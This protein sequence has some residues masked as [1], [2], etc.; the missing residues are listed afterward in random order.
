MRFQCALGSCVQTWLLGRGLPRTKAAFTASVSMS[1]CLVPFPALTSHGKSS[2]CGATHMN[3]PPA[4]H[5][6]S[7][8]HGSAR[9]ADDFSP[10]G[11]SPRVSGGAREIG[12]GSFPNSFAAS[13]K[14]FAVIPNR[15][16][17][18]QNGFALSPNGFAVSQNGSAVFPDGFAVVQNHSAVS[19]K[20]SAVV[21]NGSAISQN[22]FARSQNRS[23]ESKNRPDFAP[24][25]WKHATYVKTIVF[26]PFST[27]RPHPV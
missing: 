7:L 21:Q 27:L 12:F 24:F 20:G 23:A 6:F 25:L 17:V 5:V 8:S 18:S 4:F 3:P 19:Q 2:A 26:D 11:V 15:S 9:A 14:D 13:R 10:I 1:A 16:A 22:G